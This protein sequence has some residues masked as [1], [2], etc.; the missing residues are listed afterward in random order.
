MLGCSLIFS[1]K[2]FCRAAFFLCIPSQLIRAF[3]CRLHIRFR[4]CRRRKCRQMALRG[5]GMPTD[6]TGIARLQ[7]ARQNTGLLTEKRPV[8][9]FIESIC[10]F[11]L[12]KRPFEG[13]LGIRIHPAFVFQRC[14]KL[15]QCMQLIA[16]SC[17][18]CLLRGFRRKQ[19]IYV[20]EG[21]QL[22]LRCFELLLR[23]LLLQGACLLFCSNPVQLLLPCRLQLHTCSE[24]RILRQ[25]LCEHGDPALQFFSFRLPRLLRFIVLLQHVELRLRLL[26]LHLRTAAVRLQLLIRSDRRQV[27]ADLFE[28]R[29]H[30]VDFRLELS[31]SHLVVRDDPLEQ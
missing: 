21:L 23:C 19:R 5:D 13:L 1:T 16:F 7:T 20:S 27:A 26:E 12:R 17:I 25:H 11:I 29:V 2:P 28:R 4:R 15:R 24:L 18:L 6:R 3:L 8:A 22:P 9:I 14:K 10:L 30:L 31:A